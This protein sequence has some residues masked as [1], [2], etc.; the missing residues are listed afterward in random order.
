MQ[1]SQYQGSI[2]IFFA[3][4]LFV[5]CQDTCF[6]YETWWHYNMGTLPS[7]IIFYEANQCNGVFHWDKAINASFDL[8]FIV[9]PNKLLDKLS[10]CRTLPVVLDALLLW[11]WLLWVRKYVVLSSEHQR[12]NYCPLWGVSTTD[13]CIFLTK[14]QQGGDQILWMCLSA[15]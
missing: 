8:H 14:G 11:W 3:N 5:L 7:L 4:L 13:R 15:D 6:G 2:Y 12:P 9:S 1:H 10:T